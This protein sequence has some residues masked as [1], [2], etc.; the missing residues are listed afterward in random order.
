MLEV[1]AKRHPDEEARTHADPDVTQ[2]D[3]VLLPSTI[4]TLSGACD[5]PTD[6]GIHPIIDPSL[7]EL[8][9]DQSLLLYLIRYF[10]CRPLL[11]KSF[12]RSEKRIPWSHT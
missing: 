8:Y 9:F 12:R 10:M 3:P 4:S 7:R 6:E 11:L 2:R 1:Q 5:P